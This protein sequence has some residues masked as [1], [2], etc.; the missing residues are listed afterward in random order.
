MRVPCPKLFLEL[1]LVE[2]AT[3]ISCSLSDFELFFKV[4]L[5]LRILNAYL[6]LV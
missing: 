1:T 6:M 2:T 3:V 5:W 4:D